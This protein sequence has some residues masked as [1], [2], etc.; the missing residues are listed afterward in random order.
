M[1]DHPRVVTSF[2]FAPASLTK[3]HNAANAEVITVH[4]DNELQ[5]ALRD[6]EVLCGS[7]V[8]E[9]WREVAPHLR[10]LQFPGAGIDKLRHHPILQPDSGVLVTTASGVHITNITEYVF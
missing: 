2:G 9:N 7:D 8:P 4:S 10:W 5:A 3:I 6:A 1:S